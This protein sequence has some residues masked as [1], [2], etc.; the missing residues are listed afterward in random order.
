M[1]G[2]RQRALHSLTAQL[3]LSRELRTRVLEDAALLQRVI[4]AAEVVTE[5]LRRGNKVLVAGNG[6]SAADAQHFAAELVGRYGRRERRAL[7]ALALTTDTSLLTAVANDYSFDDVFARQV[8][9]LGNVGDLLVGISTSGNSPNVV[10]ALV[11]A[12]ECGLATLG[13]TGTGG[14]KMATL[15]DHLVAVPSDE[16]PRIQELHITLLHILC[17]LVEQALFEPE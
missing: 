5:T 14:G 9:G 10:K 11:G 2:D 6:G 16:T 13:F 15:C 12:R 8:Q 1:A 17:E 7:P 4:D 3:E